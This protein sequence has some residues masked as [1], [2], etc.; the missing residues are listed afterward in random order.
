[1]MRGGR[2]VVL[3][4]MASL[5][6]IVCTTG[7][8][9]RDF[10]RRSNGDPSVRSAARPTN[11]D[12]LAVERDGSWTPWWTPESAPTHWGG[13]LPVVS[14]ALSWKPTASAGV[15]WGELHLSGPGEAWRLRVIIARIDPRRAHIRVDTAFDGSIAHAGWTV[16]RAPANAIVAVNAGQFVG[17]LPWGWVVI[18]GSEFLSPG[19][20]PLS[21]AVAIDSSGSLHWARADGV[22]SLRTMR[23]VSSALQSYPTLLTGDG[24]V[25]RALQPRFA[26]GR[27]DLAHRDARLAIGQLRDGRVIIA[28]T[29][30]DV[31]DGALDYVPLG[32]TTPEMAALMGALGCSNAVMLDGGISS[33]MMIRTSTAKRLT[34]RGLRHVPLGLVV[35]PW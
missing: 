35:L 5:L 30:L 34:W 8:A 13:A 28:L 32:L 10:S 12:A 11:D 14:R 15:Q 29:R 19:R 27:V 25:P 7:W 9:P 26:D 22:A 17:S 23:G 16:D 18:G 3:W 2:H 24:D 21:T 1:M 33:Q 4:T 20:G 6:S 31:L